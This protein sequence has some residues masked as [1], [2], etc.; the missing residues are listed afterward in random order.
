M[1]EARIIDYYQGK[2][3]PS[4]YKGLTISCLY[5]SLEKTL[6]E[7]EALPLHNHIC[8]ILR[9]KFGIEIRG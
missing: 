8:S 9:E 5:R 4:G 6:T 3:I 1:Q 2:Q 7:Q